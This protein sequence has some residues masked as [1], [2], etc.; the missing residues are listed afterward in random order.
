VGDG[1]E[2]TVVN[3]H[4]EKKMKRK[5]K[6]AEPYRLSPNP[7]INIENFIFQEAKIR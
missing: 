1:D 2:P 7:K 4:T 5:G 6:G 3:L